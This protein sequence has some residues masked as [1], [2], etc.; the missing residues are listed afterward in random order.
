MTTPQSIPLPPA[1]F[2]GMLR[3]AI[4]PR[5]KRA[6]HTVLDA[7]RVLAGSPAPTSTLRYAD[8]SSEVIV[9]I[10]HPIAG[11]LMKETFRFV[12]SP[13]GL[14]T[15]SLAR[16]LHD[17]E[18]RSVRA[19][20]VPD[21]RRPELGLPAALYPEVSLPFVL[22]WVPQDEPRRSVYAW[23]NDRFI[24]KLYVEPHG[25]A[26]LHV[27]GRIRDVAEVVMYPDLNDW[28]PLGTVLT[29]LAKPFLPKYHMWYE[30]RPPYRLVRFEGPYGPPGAPEIVLELSE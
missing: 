3:Y 17:A 15:S 4:R 1:D 25:R 26:A 6:F 12:R 5:E 20:H 21:F 16:E 14:V 29:R 10:E 2:V 22:G 27:G 13:G 18:G 30:R 8:E 23:I 24:A 9:A 7:K 11:G 28:V 19:E